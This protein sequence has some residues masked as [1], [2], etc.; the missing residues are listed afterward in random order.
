MRSK[1]VML[2]AAALSLGF[3]QAAWAADMPAK[4]PIVKAPV[5]MPFS[6]TGFYIGGVVGYGWATGQ[7][8][9]RDTCA[10][11]GVVYPETDPNG[12]NG[13]ITVGYNYQIAQWVLGLEGDW[14]WADMHGSS[15]STTGF[16]C[17]ATAG[18]DG[19]F[20]KIKSFETARARVGY[21]FDRWLP[22]ITAGAA[23]TQIDASLGTP[24]LASGSTTKTS[25]VVGGGLE[26]AFWQNFSAKAEYL[27][28]SKLGDF[29]YGPTICGAPGCFAHT[30]AVNEI[31]FGLNYRFGNLF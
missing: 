31:R 8:C 23:F 9:D 20:T 13:G 4:A 22:Y 25:F 30:S 17:G 12:W 14:S 2:V 1:I 27:Y 24:T 28:I 11:P 19:C 29:L 21:A 6:W 10:L 26:Y 15:P 5:V 3:A 7:H 18:V 16:G